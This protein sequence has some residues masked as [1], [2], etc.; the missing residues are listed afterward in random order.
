MKNGFLN[1]DLNVHNT[2]LHCTLNYNT[3]TG[4]KYVHT[5]KTN[6]VRN[7]KH[8]LIANF[9]LI[10]VSANGEISLFLLVSC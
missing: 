5:T 2:A 6:I 9:D 4:V 10:T 3:Q 8:K 7:V 1:A